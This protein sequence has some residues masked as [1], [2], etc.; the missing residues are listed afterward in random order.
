MDG[1][2]RAEL[3]D[4][5]RTGDPISRSQ[6]GTVITGYL[7]PLVEAHRP[8]SAHGPAWVAVPVGRSHQLRPGDRADTGHPQVH[9]L[10]WMAFALVAVAVAVQPLVRV[11]E[12]R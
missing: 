12:G 8:R 9:P 4:H 1:H 7:G 5:R 2:G 11:V 6:Q 3:L 10:D